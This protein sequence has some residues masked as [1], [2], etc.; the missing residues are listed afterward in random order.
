MAV[1]DGLAKLDDGSYKC[2]LCDEY[3]SW[4]K[5][6]VKLHIEKKHQ[7]APQHHGEA[8]NMDDKDNIADEDNISKMDRVEEFEAANRD[9]AHRNLKLAAAA[10]LAAVEDHIDGA[11][12]AVIDQAGAVVDLAEVHSNEVDVVQRNDSGFQEETPERKK[13]LADDSAAPVEK[14]V[15]MMQRR[16]KEL[17]GREKNYQRQ[18]KYLE[19]KSAATEK[20]AQDQAKLLQDQQ[21]DH[22]KVQTNLVESQAKIQI[23]MTRLDKLQLKV[24]NLNLSNERDEKAQERFIGHLKTQIA[25]RDATISRLLNEQRAE[26]RLEEPV[27]QVARLNPP[28]RERPAEGTRRRVLPSE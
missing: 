16:I 2:L 1:N 6:P 24:S 11:G 25:S 22:M 10:H 12:A 21:E 20:D 28:E 9:L 17:E 14:D 3:W 26:A 13:E 5:G 8:D 7:P 15:A 18:I 27:P 4:K 19:S 23:L